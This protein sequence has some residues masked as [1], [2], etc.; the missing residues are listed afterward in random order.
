MNYAKQSQMRKQPKIVG[1][2]PYLDFSQLNT[3]KMCFAMEN[4]NRESILILFCKTQ[5]NIHFHMEN[6]NPETVNKDRQIL[7]LKFD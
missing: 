2:F 3:K 1:R 4:P 5:K 7:Y 6:P